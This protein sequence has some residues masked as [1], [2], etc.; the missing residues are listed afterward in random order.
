MIHTNSTNFYT[1]FEKPQS[2]EDSIT[3]YLAALS[4]IS[5]LK[6]I[7]DPVRIGTPNGRK[8]YR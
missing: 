4:T 1:R 7:L 8:S 5:T 2:P 6:K 3:S